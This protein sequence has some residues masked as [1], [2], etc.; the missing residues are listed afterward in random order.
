MGRL[1]PLPRVLSVKA[2]PAGVAVTAYSV[3][4]SAPLRMLPW[5]VSVG[6]FAHAL[7]WATLAKLGFG[8][9]SR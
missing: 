8:V 1:K 7:R 6:M 4:F 3:F 5:P 9:A 2:L